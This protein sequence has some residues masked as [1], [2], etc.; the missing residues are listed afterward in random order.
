MENDALLERIIKL[1]AHQMALDAT[2]R[3]FFGSSEMAGRLA[4][5]LD[6]HYHKYLGV[7]AAR[8]GKKPLIDRISEDIRTHE[9]ACRL[10]GIPMMEL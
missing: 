6:Q 10:K 3:D 1:E 7:V 4:W 5:F 8:T 2:I 9:K